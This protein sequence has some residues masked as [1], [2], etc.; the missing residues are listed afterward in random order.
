MPGGIVRIECEMKKLTRLKPRKGLL[1]FQRHGVHAFTVA[2]DAVDAAAD[3]L[4][5]GHG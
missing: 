1:R 3:L 5:G 2:H 4:R